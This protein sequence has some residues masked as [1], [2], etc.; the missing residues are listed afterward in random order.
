MEN[1][2]TY[3]SKVVLKSEEAYDK[4]TLY[5]RRGIERKKGDT[6]HQNRL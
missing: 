2:K 3:T 5:V 6:S 1:W 4:V